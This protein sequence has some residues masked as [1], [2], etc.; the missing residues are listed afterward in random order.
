M[1]YL[2]NWSE[3]NRMISIA[4]K[5][6]SMLVSGKR[7]GQR[8]DCVDLT[9]SINQSGFEQVP[10]GDLNHKLS[11]YEHVDKL[12]GNAINFLDLSDLDF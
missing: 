5:T 4:T 10:G 6:K 1:N 3:N 7:L 9:G 8:M 11:F 2:H 12:C